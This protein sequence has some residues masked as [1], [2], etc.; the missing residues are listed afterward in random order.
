MPFGKAIHQI[1][2]INHLILSKVNKLAEFCSRL[3]RTGVCYKRKF[4]SKRWCVS[5]GWYVSEGNYIMKNHVNVPTSPKRT[6]R[7]VRFVF[8]N[9]PQVLIF[10]SIYLIRH[11]VT[12]S[13]DL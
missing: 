1:D 10:P 2:L 11:N 8:C 7:W 12:G 6:H 3:I 5:G 4:V 13:E 9:R